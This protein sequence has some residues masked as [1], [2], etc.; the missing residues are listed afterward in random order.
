MHIT[1]A[2][3]LVDRAYGGPEEGGWYY[4]CGE[5]AE[6]YA[7]HARRFPKRSAQAAEEYAE[8]LRQTLLPEIN[9]GRRPIYSVLSSGQYRVVVCRG[10]PV[11]YPQHHV[12]YQ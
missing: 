12:N 8:H 6:E 11:P 3:F 4:N 1:V 9:R 2:I 10:E 5:P 7:S